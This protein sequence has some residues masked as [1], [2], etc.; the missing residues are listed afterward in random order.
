MQQIPDTLLSAVAR[1][2]KQGLSAVA[3]VMT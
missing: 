1:G 3:P 2:D